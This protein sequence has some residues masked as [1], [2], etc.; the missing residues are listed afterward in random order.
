[1]ARMLMGMWLTLAAEMLPL[2]P[3]VIL[4]GLARG[5]KWQSQLLCE[6]GWI[7]LSLLSLPLSSRS[8]TTNFAC[9]NSGLVGADNV[10]LVACGVN[11][12]SNNVPYWPV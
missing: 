11:P 6:W 3:R 8:S 10:A 2:S 1:M 12:D 7:A 4:V 5:E 9:W